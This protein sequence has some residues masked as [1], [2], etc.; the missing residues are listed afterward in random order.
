MTASPIPVVSL[1][2]IGLEDQPQLVSRIVQILRRR[3]EARSGAKVARDEEADFQL[4]LHI[5]DSLE[6]ESFRIRQEGNSQVTLSGGDAP[7]L[8]YGV[9]KFLRTARYLPEGFIP[10]AWEGESHPAR[11]LRG[12]Y[13][14]THFH[15]YYHDAP[16]DEVVRYVEELA[17]WGVNTIQ[18]WYD[19]HH[20]TGIDDPAAGAMIARLH[21][22]LAAAKNLGLRTCLVHLG[23]EAYAD[24][25]PALRADYA[26]GRAT[27]QVELCPNKPGATE[28]MLQWYGEVLEAFADIVPDY[29]VFGP[30]DQGG[31]ACE[32]CKPWG[33]NGYLKIAQAKAAL[34]RQHFPETQIILST[35]L[36]DYG[37]EQGEWAGL[38]AAFAQDHSWCDYI[39]ADSHGEYPAY[40]LQHGVPGGLPLLNFPEISMW[41]MHPWGGFGANPLPRRF[42][43]I[44]GT[45]KNQLSGGFPYSEGI[46]EDIN[47]VLCLQLYWD[48]RRSAEDILREYIAYEYAPEVADDVLAAIEILEQN[49]HHLWTMN[50]EFQRQCRFA[51]N[52]QRDP[53]EAFEKMQHADAQLGQSAKN[54]WRWR[55]LYLRALLDARL[56][57]TQGF[58]GDDICEGAFEELTDIYHARGAEYKC[59]PPTKAAI[60]KAGSSEQGVTH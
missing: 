1:S 47:K 27:Y 26:T 37:K 20:Y 41:E 50:W 23:N 53:Q 30:Y 5:D 56:H 14:A 12:M 10:G 29:I 9:G 8:I 51:F 55:I 2:V 42:H 46:Y 35:W 57:S 7:A 58:W 11:P 22:I 31:C 24:S 48:P 18:V 38:D 6:P 15:N 4:R 13:F 40:P 43:R 39:Q 17:L 44:L 54:S 33:A 45:V 59:A 52:Y 34:T 21:A 36:F 49:Q 60:Q 16:I 25:P 3:I 28:L 19:M 32:K